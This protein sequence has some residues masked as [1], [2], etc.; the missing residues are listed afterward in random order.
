MLTKE[1]LTDPKKREM[2]DKYGT[3]DEQQLD[4]DMFNMFAGG[5]FQEF[6]QFLDEMMVQSV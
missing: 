1:V 5:D 3:V 4:M 2:Y 6:E